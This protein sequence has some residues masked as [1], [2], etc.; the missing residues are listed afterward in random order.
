MILVSNNK[1]RDTSGVCLE[2]N[3]SIKIE[4]QDIK[5]LNINNYKKGYTLDI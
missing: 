5:E 1:N 2:D 4:I 3:K